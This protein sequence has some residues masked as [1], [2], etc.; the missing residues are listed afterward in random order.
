[1]AA[2]QWSYK[3][4]VEGTSPW[5]AQAA[6][7]GSAKAARHEVHLRCTFRETSVAHHYAQFAPWVRAHASA[8][9]YFEISEAAHCYARSKAGHYNVTSSPQLERAWTTAL[10]RSV[11]LVLS[12]LPF[13]GWAAKRISSGG[14]SGSRDSLRI[15]G[16]VPA[17][18][19]D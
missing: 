17:L 16:L 13:D 4:K 19:G 2:A 11:V 3:K 5:S 7:G 6:H 1:M 9:L 8:F 12:G 18:V 14:F 15:E 10:N